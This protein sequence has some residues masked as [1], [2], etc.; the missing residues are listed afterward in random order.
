L[1]PCENRAYVSV[2]STTS[3]VAAFFFT[4]ST[5]FFAEAFDS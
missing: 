3:A 5:P 4:E 1:G 2:R